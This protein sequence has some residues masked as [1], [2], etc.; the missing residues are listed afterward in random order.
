MDKSLPNASKHAKSFLTVT[1]VPA[2]NGPRFLTFDNPGHLRK[3]QHH[4]P[5]SPTLTLHGDH[6]D[7]RDVH[8]KSLAA[9]RVFPHAVLYHGLEHSRQHPRVVLAFVHAA[10]LLLEPHQPAHGGHGAAHAVL[11]RKHSVDGDLDELADEGEVGASPRDDLGPVAGAA[12][13]ELRRDVRHA[14]GDGD[15]R[16][17]LL[18]QAQVAEQLGEDLL[19]AALAHGLVDEIPVLGREEAVAPQDLDVGRLGDEVRLVRD[20]DAH[21]PVAVGEGRQRA[22]AGLVARQRGDLLEEFRGFE[23][24]GEG[25]PVRFRDAVA[26]VVGVTEVGGVPGEGFPEF[27]GA[28]ARE[29]GA[30]GG[31]EFVGAEGGGGGH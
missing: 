17:G 30:D 9:G 7:W 6:I 18:R 8:L 28:V 11:D 19:T 29:A 16:V 3:K 5:P 27:P 2:S 1:R 25:L 22:C 13:Q 12:R 23:R 14:A 10:R 20:D 4:P 26:E 21:E 24:H 31:R 15:G